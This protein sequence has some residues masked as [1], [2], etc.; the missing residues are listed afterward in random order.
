V[1][2]GLVRGI[3]EAALASQAKA[4]WSCYRIALA[5]L[6]EAQLAVHMP[7]LTAF[8]TRKEG[9]WHAVTF[10]LAAIGAFKAEAVGLACAYIR[11]ALTQLETN[12]AAT[13]SLV[14]E[15]RELKEKYT[16]LNHSVHIQPV[17]E[18]A[19]E[20]EPDFRCEPLPF[21]V[22]PAYELD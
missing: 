2:A 13:P 3:G 22:E 16:R 7:Q 10:K 18:A 17:P 1:W 20:P 4:A 11:T 5:D 6:N 14:A 9:Y 15:V 12:Q 8:L 21:S 19:P